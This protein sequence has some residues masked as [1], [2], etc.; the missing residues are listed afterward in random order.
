MMD[1][2]RPIISILKLHFDDIPHQNTINNS[3]DN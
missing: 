2:M 1:I 3:N